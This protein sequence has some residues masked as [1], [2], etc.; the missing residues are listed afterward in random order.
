MIGRLCQLD[1]LRVH[2]II[3]HKAIFSPT[4]KTQKAILLYLVVIIHVCPARTTPG[5][6]VDWILQRIHLIWY[7]WK[8]DAYWE[9][10]SVVQWTTIR[11]MGV[12]VLIDAG[13]VLRVFLVSLELLFQLGFLL[14]H[15]GV[16]RGKLGRICAFSCIE[17][18]GILGLLFSF[19]E[20][21]IYRHLSIF[22]IFSRSY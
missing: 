19:F 11:Q 14:C 16:I 21:S 15:F 7:G 5:N 3:T 13:V 1:T 10:K 4:Y 22:I 18:V 12:W 17:I 6:L 9:L 20:D 2:L 8:S